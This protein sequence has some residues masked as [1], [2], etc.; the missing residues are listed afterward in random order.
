MNSDVRY[1]TN[2]GKKADIG[3]CRGCTEG[4]FL[5]PGEALF[6]L[7]GETDKSRSPLSRQTTFSG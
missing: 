1:C 5:S 3:S 2:S 7:S 4:V 6:S